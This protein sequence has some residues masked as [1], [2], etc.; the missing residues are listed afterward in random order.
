MNRLVV[1]VAVTDCWSG[2]KYSF[3]FTRRIRL[4]YR[5]G[6]TSGSSSVKPLILTGIYSFYICSSKKEAEV[7]GR[8]II[9]IFT[10]KLRNGDKQV[11]NN[12]PGYELLLLL[13]ISRSF[14][15]ASWLVLFAKPWYF[16]GSGNFNRKILQITLSSSAITYRKIHF[17]STLDGDGLKLWW[18]FIFNYL[19]IWQ[20]ILQ[21]IYYCKSGTYHRRPA[22]KSVN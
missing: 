15:W 13:T 11:L 3:V 9:I 12:F 5:S 22:T 20:T 16:L 4:W 10:E 2:S 19:S 8:S 6:I 17:H 14:Y 7:R 21:I 18:L 1:V